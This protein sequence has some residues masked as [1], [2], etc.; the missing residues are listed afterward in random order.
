MKEFNKYERHLMKAEAIQSIGSRIAYFKADLQ[1]DIDRLSE[2][3]MELMAAE[4][5]DTWYI[6]STEKEQMKYAMELTIW[7]KLEKCVDKEMG[8]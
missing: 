7:E 5:P 2:K 6:E 3:L 1:G 8:L 4:E